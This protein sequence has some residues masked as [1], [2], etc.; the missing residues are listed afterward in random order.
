MTLYTPSHWRHISFRMILPQNS[1][2][3]WKICS[4]QEN[5]AKVNTSR[6]I[7]RKDVGVGSNEFIT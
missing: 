6:K 2:A 4:R 1:K 7:C 3:K 5:K